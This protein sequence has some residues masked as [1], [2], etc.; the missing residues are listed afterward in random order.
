MTELTLAT[1]NALNSFGDARNADALEVVKGVDADVVAL[2]EFTRRAEAE[3]DHSLQSQEKLQALGYT[4]CLVTEY[5]P[6]LSTERN[7]HTMSLWSR[8]SEPGS[9]QLEWFGS[10]YGLSVEVPDFGTIDAVHLPDD[11]VQKRELAADALL[12][13]DSM[14][15]MGDFNDMHRSDPRS[16]VPR[17][18]DLLSRFLPVHDYYDESKKLQRLMG[19]VQRIGY[20]ARGRAM[21]RLTEGGFIDADQTHRPTIG[22][23]LLA[24]QI[25]HIMVRAGV[26]VHQVDVLPRG[27][28]SANSQLLSDHSP[29]V[30]RVKL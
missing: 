27:L 29:V 12:R 22:K 5:Y 19:K 16:R 24:Y 15:A 6:P 10:R 2:E 3:S 23:G 20:M 7:A 25:D 1:W 9:V 4:A 14:V 13:R 21:A 17:A 11:S 8:V 18:V 26:E 30:A 28:T